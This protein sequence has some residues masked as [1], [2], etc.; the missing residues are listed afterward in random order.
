MGGYTATPGGGGGGGLP[1]IWRMDMDGATTNWTL[2][3]SEDPSTLFTAIAGAGT[4]P[5][6]TVLERNSTNGIVFDLN[7]GT[8]IQQ[9]AVLARTLNSELPRP[10]LSSW[11][12]WAI[13]DLD[14]LDTG[15]AIDLQVVGTAFT[16]EY[17][18]SQLNNV[19]GVH[20]MDNKQKRAT[21]V[22]TNS[23]SL[24]THWNKRS[25]WRLQRGDS[26]QKA[27]WQ[28][29]G[30]TSV[31]GD[32]PIDIA[33]EI[34]PTIDASLGISLRLQFA[35]ANGNHVGGQIEAMGIY[36]MPQE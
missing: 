6:W 23:V 2:G 22:T 34:P 27:L 5:A 30:T 13:I 21:A 14:Y 16:D 24:T 7:N 25:H 1:T 33:A 8:G 10:L 29:I 28:E 36:G 31:Q 11:G 20:Y 32:G 26:V 18:I 15:A 4:L 3:S 17:S 12:V 35:V 9:T 19:I